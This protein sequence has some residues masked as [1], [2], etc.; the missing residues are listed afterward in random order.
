MRMIGYDR[1]K[2]GALLVSVGA[3]FLAPAA[4]AQACPPAHAPAWGYWSHGVTA[5]HG[6]ESR[7]SGGSVAGHKIG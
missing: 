6:A 1:I 2:R 5:A 7:H 3:A 4:T